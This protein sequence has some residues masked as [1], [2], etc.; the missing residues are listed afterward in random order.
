M[1]C[2][3]YL[4]KSSNDLNNEERLSLIN[5]REAVSFRAMM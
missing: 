2:M 5:L 4:G 1:I 3:C